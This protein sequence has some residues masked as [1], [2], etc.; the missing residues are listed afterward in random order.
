LNDR[1]QL[2]VGDTMER[3]EVVAVDLPAVRDVEVAVM[4]G[5]TCALTDAGAYCWGDNAH[6]QLADGRH[7]HD[8]CDDGLATVDC[9]FT[10]VR[11]P[12][13]DEAVELSLG[14]LHGCALDSDGG[15]ACWGDGAAGQL[16][17]PDGAAG[18]SEPAAVPDLDDIVQVSAGGL[19]TCALRADG[20]VLCWG[21]NDEGQLGDGRLV[22]GDPCRLG[23]DVFDC[24]RTPA[25]VVGLDDATLVSAGAKHTCALRSSGDVLCWGW[26]ADR[27]LGDGDR[28]RDAA[29]VT[30]DGL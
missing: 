3:H 27:Q 12:G 1:G 24:A 23:A 14:A 30:V 26:S 10:P 22:H 4:R 21:A 7:D 2:G 16:G 13:L 29:P 18:R 28:H 15:V 8:R 25:V 11:A 9:A 19:H 20:R 6:G 17:V 5:F